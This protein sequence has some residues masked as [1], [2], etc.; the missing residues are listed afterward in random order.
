MPIGYVTLKALG[1]RVKAVLF[2]LFD[3][4]VLI[5]SGDSFYMPALQKLHKSLVK[6][7]V[8]VPF[9]EFSRVYFEVRDQ[10]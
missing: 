9:E 4:L 1:M 3:T 8:K 10:V 2:D 5:E 7:G 6:K